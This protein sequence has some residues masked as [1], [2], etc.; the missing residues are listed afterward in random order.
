MDKNTE[1]VS[2]IFRHPLSIFIRKIGFKAAL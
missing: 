1:G 2:K